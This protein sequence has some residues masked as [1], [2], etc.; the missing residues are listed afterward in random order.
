[1]ASQFAKIYQPILKCE[2]SAFVDLE[3]IFDGLPA[4]SKHGRIQK[5]FATCLVAINFWVENQADV[6]AGCLVV[7]RLTLLT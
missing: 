5:I 6:A 3:H 7:A 4:H 2:W 1:L